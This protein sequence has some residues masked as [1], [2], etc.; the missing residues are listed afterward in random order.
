[1]NIA[2]IIGLVFGL[3]ILI[4]SAFV[5]SGGDLARF[6][7]IPGVCIV[8]G[9]TFASTFICYPL[10]NVLGVFGTFLQAMK[11]DELPVVNYINSVVRLAKTA[12][13][14][15]QIQLEKEL[16]Q[17][18]NFFL[19]GAIQMLVDGYS[20]EE[21]ESILNTRIEN[22]YEQEMNGVEILKTM[23]G[24]CP[25]FGIIGTLIG[26]INMLSAM[27]TDMSALGGAM[28]VALLTTLYG[29]L[30]SNIFFVPFA[31]KVEGRLKERVILMNV[32]RDGVI[33]IKD[34]T[35]SSIVQDKLKAYTA[36]DNWESIKEGSAE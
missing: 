6:V 31:V 12:T 32:I 5:S 20:K 11:A 23:S 18:D 28:A 21:I 1:M 29:V 16:T 8:L 3:G 15:G 9:G 19:Q 2:T 10:K 26:L 25:G 36:P 27:G 30:F 17:I 24:F 22:I 7:D 13:Q 14:K 33:F 34:K 4:V 35:P